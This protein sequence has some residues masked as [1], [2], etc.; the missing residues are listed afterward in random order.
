[1]RIP[2]LVILSLLIAAPAVASPLHSKNGE[3]INV[4][5]AGKR[6]RGI[7]LRAQ[8]SGWRLELGGG[9]RA[10]ASLFDV[11]DGVSP[12]K[13]VVPVVDGA[14]ALDAERF[15]AGHAYRVELRGG[16]ATII[17]LYPPK[18]SRASHVDL[19]DDESPASDD[20]IAITPKSAL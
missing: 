13:W 19:S 10:S 12:T 4:R 5:V 3:A 1:M 14:L 17:Y 16:D 2:P 18:Q 15:V 7:G 8:S 9:A 6:A 11:T 20:G